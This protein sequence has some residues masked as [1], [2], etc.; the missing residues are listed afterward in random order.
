MAQYSAEPAQSSQRPR[1]LPELG[2]LATPLAWL[3]ALRERAAPL[4]GRPHGHAI[5]LGGAGRRRQCS[6]FTRTPRTRGSSF[7]GG[8][9]SSPHNRRRH[10]AGRSR[11]EPRI[12]SG[13]HGS[14]PT[15]PGRNRPHPAQRYR[16]LHDPTGRLRAHHRCGKGEF[17]QHRAAQQEHTELRPQIE[18]LARKVSSLDGIRWGRREMVRTALVDMY[19][20]LLN[21]DGG[22]AAAPLF[23]DVLEGIA[24]SGLCRPDDMLY[25]DSTP[26]PPKNQS[27]KV[28]EQVAAKGLGPA[29]RA[30]L[31][32]SL[33]RKCVP[34]GLRAIYR[35]CTKSFSCR[36]AARHSSATA[37]LSHMFESVH[38]VTCGAK[39][40][41]AP[42]SASAFLRPKSS[43]KCRL[44][45]NAT[46][47]N[48]YDE[49]PPPRV[50]LPALSAIMSR[51]Q[52]RP[53]GPLYM[54]KLDLTNAYWSIILPRRWRRTFVVQ[55]GQRRWR[56]TRLP[57]GWKYSPA[58][59]HRLVSGIVARALR[60]TNVD[61][62]VY[63]DDILITATSPAAARA[64]V[65]RV[66]AALRDAGFIISP[67]SELEP[68][69]CITFLGKRLDSV[70]RSVSNSVDMLKATLRL[71]LQGVGTGRMPAREMA[72]FLGRLQWV[73]RPMGGA[74]V[75]LAGAYNAMLH[76]S[77]FFSRTLIRATGTALLLSF[78]SHGLSDPS[79]V[80]V[81][82][83][84]S[85]A[86]PCGR[87]FRIGVVGSPGFYRSYVCPRWVRS[88]QQAE[89]YGVYGALKAA[90]GCRLRSVA[91][92]ID[93]EAVRV[94]S[95]S[96]R[97][98]TDCPVQLR[99]LRRIF[100]LRAWSGLQ[101]SVFRVPS[102]V[103]PA[104]PLSRKHEMLSRASMLSLCEQ[105][106]VAWGESHLPF[107]RLRQSVPTPRVAP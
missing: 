10:L 65:Q 47:I 2:L 66:A 31:A 26:L 53:P 67:K 84:F 51:F 21:I 50:K 80:R 36:G 32:R 45:L 99:L 14:G 28:P 94:Q 79:H 63:L 101:L 100:W 85:D 4:L 41:S 103:N 8:R 95:A 89:L 76:R 38:A 19:L 9:S 88:L 74:S 17:V 92:G 54:C 104:D 37:P 68:S 42:V 39:P 46:A 91:V 30:S 62:D 7:L 33:W 61:W 71:W 13:H 57:F 52:H 55:A 20:A 48:A 27:Q 96:L 11:R 107:D 24:E 25:D 40:T 75:F 18:L 49:R 90:A 106:R 98:S 72:R 44:L 87:R 82:T 64:G 23:R 56:F 70:R 93:N 97:A 34:R 83:F 15:S 12:R 5:A 78:P 43:D 59:C 6:A 3:A 1:Q 102:A 58:I 60:G 35:R 77:P 86:A 73:F 105:R 22:A 16:V 29:G 69:T 81:H